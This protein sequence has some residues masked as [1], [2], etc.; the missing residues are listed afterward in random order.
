MSDIEVDETFDDQLDP[1]IYLDD[2]ELENNK[3]DYLPN[4]T[5]IELDNDDNENDY[6]DDKD[7]DGEDGEDIDLNDDNYDYDEEYSELYDEIDE[8]I[9]EINIDENKKTKNINKKTKIQSK[10]PISNKNKVSFIDNELENDSKIQYIIKNDEKI[11]SNILTIYEITELIGIRATQ[12]ANGAPI[13]TDIEYINDPIEMAKKEI[14]NNK[15]PLYVKR[16]IGLD[17]YELWDPNI[18]IKP[19]L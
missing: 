11:T 2:D 7:E 14:I 10:I 19:K 16:Y 6:I 12:I 13:F 4:K 8:D 15:C 1:D 5:K 18:M 17:K 3:N 9:E